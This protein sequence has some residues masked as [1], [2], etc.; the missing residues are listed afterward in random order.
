[1]VKQCEKEI[2]SQEWQALSSMDK[3]S[4]IWANSDMQYFLLEIRNGVYFS[5]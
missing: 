1:M 5:E 2:L 4:H 3:S